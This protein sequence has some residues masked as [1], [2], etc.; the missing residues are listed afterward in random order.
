[1]LKVSVRFQRFIRI[2]FITSIRRHP[3][4]GTAPPM[5]NE[6][7]LSPTHFVH[8]IRLQ[9][10]DKVPL[11][12]GTLSVQ[13]LAGRL[14]P[15]LFGV[16]LAE[17]PLPCGVGVRDEFRGLRL[18]HSDQHWLPR[19]DYFTSSRVSSLNARQNRLDSQLDIYVGHRSRST[20]KYGNLSMRKRDRISC[21][22]KETCTARRTDNQLIGFPRCFIRSNRSA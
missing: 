6:S 4:Y 5:S 17:M 21:L 11:D 15:Q 1:M 16:V 20:A 2:K 12:V 8:L 3:I 10:T 19:S 13:R 7:P 9:M 14:L 18:A 22:K